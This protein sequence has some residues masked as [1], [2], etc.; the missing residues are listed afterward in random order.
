MGDWEDAIARYEGA[1]R[2]Q[3]DQ[4]LLAARLA[5]Y[6]QVWAIK[7]SEH[8]RARDF[9]Y[10]RW[11]KAEVTELADRID[12]VERAFATL[13]VFGDY[14]SA[15]K[16]AKAAS[17]HNGALAQLIELLLASGGEDNLREAGNYQSLTDRI[18]R[19]AQRV[20]A[21]ELSAAGRTDA[22]SAADTGKNLPRE[23]EESPPQ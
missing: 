10:N 15:R 1:L 19:L 18:S 6:K 9:V 2:I 5:R 14:L 23:M 16:L 20:A 22:T 8:Q 13:E 7:S 11:A 17:D 4:P 21:F 3:P 12:E